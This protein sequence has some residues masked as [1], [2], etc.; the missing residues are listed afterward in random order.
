MSS[1][2]VEDEMSLLR[3]KRFGSRFIDRE[4]SEMPK[5]QGNI[6]GP[7]DNGATSGGRVLL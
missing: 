7:S 5:M 6:Q 2:E 3:G 1:L 4:E